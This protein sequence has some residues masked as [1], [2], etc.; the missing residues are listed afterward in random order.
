MNT[1]AEAATHDNM[2]YDCRFPAIY[3]GYDFRSA[4]AIGDSWRQECI[5]GAHLV[6][7]PACVKGDQGHMAK[8]ELKKC[9]SV[10]LAERTKVRTFYACLSSLCFRGTLCP[11]GHFRQR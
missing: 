11:R 3:D 4:G 8:N 2:Y 1:F 9:A 5:D 7:V 6:L 10:P